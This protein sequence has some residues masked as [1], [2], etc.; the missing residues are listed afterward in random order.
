MYRESDSCSRCRA[1][2]A[3]HQCDFD[4]EG[5]PVCARCHAL[6]EVD[7]A[8]VRWH[9]DARTERWLRRAGA[10]AALTAVVA[11]PALLLLLMV[12]MLLATF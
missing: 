11:L 3:P 4:G 2:L 8:L 6:G 12:G 1:W 5:R 7:R 10:A 9:E